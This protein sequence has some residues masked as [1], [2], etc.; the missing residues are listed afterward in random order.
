MRIIACGNRDR[1]DDGLALLVSERLH[2]LGIPV[3][4]QSGEASALI[5]AWRGEDDVILVDTVVTGAPA[6]TVRL[7]ENAELLPVT[8]SKA[9]THGFG[10]A[11]AI[12]LARVLKL[13]PRRLRLVGIEGTNFSVGSNV[14]PKLTA[15]VEEAVELIMQLLLDKPPLS[16]EDSHQ[17]KPELQR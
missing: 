10:V 5:E 9:S 4:T 14:F 11:E 1:T 7:W 17:S 12:E 16:S 6:G 8:E 13:L 2:S 15:S 3:E